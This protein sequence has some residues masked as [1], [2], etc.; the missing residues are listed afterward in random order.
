MPDPDFHVFEGRVDA[1]VRGPRSD[2]GIS[3]WVEYEVVTSDWWSGQPAERVRVRTTVDSTGVSAKLGQTRHF[4]GSIR[5]DGAIWVN[6]CSNIQGSGT[7]IASFALPPVPVTAA[8]AALDA[9]DAIA[10]T[11]A[12]QAGSPEHTHRGRLADLAVATCDVTLLAPVVQAGRRPSD[13]T[14]LFSC[15]EEDV[16]ALLEAAVAP[17]TD[18]VMLSATAAAAVQWRRDRV[19]LLVDAG[20][21]LNSSRGP[22]PLGR[23]MRAGDAEMEAFLVSLGAE[24][25]AR[26]WDEAVRSNLPSVRDRVLQ[27]DL[28]PIG[29]TLVLNRMVEDAR[30]VQHG[31]DHGASVG[32]IDGDQ[33]SGPLDV[34]LWTGAWD[35]ARLLLD[36]GAQRYDPLLPEVLPD[37][38]RAKLATP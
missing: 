16:P 4:S 36:A 9:G 22:S 30:F 6:D 25:T 29:A 12:L 11:A 37:D 24:Y 32:P 17:N 33:D 18:Y 28:D 3:D 27:A 23:V 35:S 19:Q 31:L 1:V 7:T 5:D 38:I 2:H 20:V 13:P 14:S 8:V 34:A 21:D 15:P 26:T 10:L